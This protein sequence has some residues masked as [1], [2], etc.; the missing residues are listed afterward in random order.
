MMYFAISGEKEMALEQM[1][2]TQAAM[3]EMKKA[4]LKSYI[5]IAESSLEPL[6]KRN[7][8]REEA[9][10]VL[11]SIKFGESGYIFGYDSKGVRLLTGDSPKGVGDNFWDLQDSRGNYIVRDVIS[12]SKTGEFMTYYFPKPSD[13]STPLPKLSYSVYIA[14]WDM[15]LGT[16]FYTDD[17]DKQIAEMDANLTASLNT[18]IW[19]LITISSVIVLIVG[20]L[21]V[22][23]NRSIMRPLEMFERSIRSFASGDADLTARMEKFTIPEF[24]RLS[25][26]FNQF[27]A[28]LQNIIQNVNA[29]GHKVVEQTTEMSKRATQVDVVTSSQR[30]ETDQVATAMTEMTTT[31]REIS[32]NANL[33]AE[34]ANDVDT[35]AKE[36]NKIIR[37]AA[38]SVQK[39]ADEVADTA[40][41]LGKLENDV[42]NISSSLNVIQ[43]IAEQTNLLALNAAI[44]AARAGEQGRGF[45]VVADEVRKLATRTQASTGEI[46]GMISQLKLASDS[47]V[48]AMTI[49]Q[50]RSQTTVKEALA[51]TESIQR[52]EKSI[53]TIMDMN[54]LI[55]TAT[56]EQSIVG[57]EISE[58]IVVISEKSSQAANLA[59]LNREGS[60]LLKGNASDLYELVERFKV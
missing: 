22:F 40:N 12:H 1:N 20:L 32:H 30:E 31:A 6:K 39:L 15:A 10:A 46:Y 50:N 58:R 54:T 2:T 27:V 9:V 7:A 60:Q 19:T 48:K 52:I 25:D 18:S 45:A 13:P 16:G 35:N 42:Q 29:V 53:S 26:N 57:Q 41:V 5:Q 56:E 24:A 21:A 47:A 14:Q 49:S 38:E 55:A 43:D 8:T 51:A 37:A 17:V 34:S 44:E 3:M 59:M 23:L 28:S 11:K 4:E 36:S 33:A